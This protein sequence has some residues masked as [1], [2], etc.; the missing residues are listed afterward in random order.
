ML[1]GLPSSIEL[2]RLEARSVG[3]DVLLQAYVREP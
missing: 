3:D 1:A 2:T